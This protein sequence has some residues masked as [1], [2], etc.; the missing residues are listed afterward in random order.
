MIESRKKDHVDIVINE[1]AQYKQTNGLEK[2]VLVHNALP[3]IDFDAVDLSIHFFSKQLKWPILITG[4]TGG[5]SQAKEIN[6]NLATLAEEFGLAFGLGS[7]RAMIE[8]PELTETYYVRDV[9]P[10]IP[11]VANIGAYQLKHYSIEQIKEMMSAV[12]ADVL[13]I[14]LNPLQEIVQKEGDRDYSGILTAIK[15]TKK[16]IPNLL[17]KETGAG[18]S[19]EVAQKL[20]SVGVEWIDVSGAGG[21]SWSKVETMRGGFVSGFDNWGIPTKVTIEECKDHAKLIGSGGIRNGIDA[22]KV[23][24]LGCEL[25]GAAFPFIKS[26][27]SGKLREFTEEFLLQLKVAAYLTGSKTHNQL[28]NARYYVL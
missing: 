11:I 20:A 3:E 8:H 23:I 21:T 22:A 24:A 26:E 28:K 1:G 15:E 17:V 7:Q 18:I 2:I 16:E 12:G 25:A 10:T 14:H 27:R 9:A 5:Y 6:R 13:A 19:R 4:M